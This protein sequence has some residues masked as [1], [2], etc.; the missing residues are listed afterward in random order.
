MKNGK[1]ADKLYMTLREEG[2][3]VYEEKRS[4]FFDLPCMWR[5]NKTRKV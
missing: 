4:E 2:H 5:M 3:A 1:E